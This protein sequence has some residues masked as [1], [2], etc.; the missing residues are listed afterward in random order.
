MKIVVKKGLDIP[1][2]G[3]PSGALRSF[4]KPRK[5]ALN[6]DPF[7]DVR[8]KV[9]VKMGE[10]VQIGQPLVENKAVPGMFFVSPAGGVVSAIRRGLKRRLLD[11]VIDVAEKEEI[12]QHDTA[13]VESK[14]GLIN[15]FLRAGIF[16]H[17]RQRPFDLIAHPE[18]LPRAIFVRAVESL[19][20]VPSADLQIKGKEPYFRAG[21]EALS[22]IAPVHLVYD[23]GST[24]Q[25]FLESK[26]CTKHTV[27]GPHPRGNFSVHIHNILPIRKSDDYTWT[28]SLIGVISIGKMVSRG[29]Y[30]HERIL[31]LGG[32]GFLETERGFIKGRMGYPLEELLKGRVQEELLCVI[33]GDPL[34]GT[35]SE[36]TEFLHFYDTAVTVLPVNVERQLLHFWRLGRKKYTATR[37]YL[38]GFFSPPKEGYSFTTNKHGEERAF[39]DGSVYDKVM[40]M[41]IPTMQLV[42]ALLA[43]D[44]E[45]AEV[46]GALEV[47]KE[48]FALPS[49][50][51]PSK[52]EMMEIVHQGLHL[53]AKEL[54]H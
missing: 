52:I 22:K 18:H 19:P 6:L 46:L 41:Q 27:R 26:D 32:S 51:C 16:P 43:Q 25:T 8:F 54:G 14:E 7:A 30:Y 35:K 1:I 36:P 31:S 39:I 53:Y 47:V 4:D 48:D 50:I 13:G 23:E 11:I 17:I 5:I 29:N 42:K 45:L 49:F 9:L 2:A 12:F 40:P 10:I 20:F 28:V 24:C 38:S 37:C 44:Y 3:A 34:T 21:L 15:L 33:S